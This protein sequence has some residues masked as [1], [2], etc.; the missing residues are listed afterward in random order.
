M[1]VPALAISFRKAWRDARSGKFVG[2]AMK[3]KSNAFRTALRSSL[4]SLAALSLTGCLTVKVISDYDDQIDSGVTQVLAD[5]TAFVNKMTPL[6][7]TTPGTYEQNK[8]FYSTE[9]GKISALEARA[10]AHKIFNICPTTGLIS[11]AIQ[12]VGS[13]KAIA[14][15]SQTQAKFTAYGA[16]IKSG[17]CE[18]VMLDQLY[19]EMED[20]KGFH[21][22]QGALGIPPQAA[23][24]ILVGGIGA[25][26]RMVI[27]VEEAKKAGQSGSK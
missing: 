12:G 21:Q 7:G 25:T 10:D 11:K 17:E 1:S 20:L 8:D 24:P 6:A 18:V 19:Q 14:S 16:S 3:S 15:N 5:T 9:E 13:M 4:I 26:V 22:A 23:D 2:D 27:A